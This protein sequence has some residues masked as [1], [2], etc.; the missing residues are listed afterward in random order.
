MHQYN[1]IDPYNKELSNT[2]PALGIGGLTT[3]IPAILVLVNLIW[4]D[5]ISPELGQAIFGVA[6]VL[7]PIIVSI[8][9]RRKVW[10]PA[11]VV[12]VVEASKSN[13]LNP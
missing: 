7:L 9:I 3:V 13:S 2:E 6:A 4:K 10:S 5:A 1:T 8:L 11:S 12:K